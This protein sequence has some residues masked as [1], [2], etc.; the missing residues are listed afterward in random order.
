[1]N[2]YTLEMDQ[3]IRNLNKGPNFLTVEQQQLSLI[4]VRDAGSSALGKLSQFR[5]L[6]PV[7][8]KVK[9]DNVF[10]LVVHWLMIA[11]YEKLKNTN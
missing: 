1:M 2:M 8:A 3:R 10:C 9:A 5:C 4:S 7:R 11:L 6:I